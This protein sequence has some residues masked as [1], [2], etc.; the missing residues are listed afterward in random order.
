MNRIWPI[1]W[2][3]FKYTALTKAFIIGSI[4][5]PICIFPLMIV[6]PILFAPTSEPLK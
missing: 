4:V 1:T 5:V 3:E 2:R 6:L